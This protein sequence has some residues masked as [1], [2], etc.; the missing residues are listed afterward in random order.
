MSHHHLLGLVISFDADTVVWY[1]M[2]V[3]LLL[4]LY[5]L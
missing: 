5:L 3:S 4:A 1:L 2:R